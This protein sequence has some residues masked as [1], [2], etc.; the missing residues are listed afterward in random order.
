MEGA[1]GTGRPARARRRRLLTLAACSLPVVLICALVASSPALVG[2]AKAE[3]ASTRLP[4][5]PRNGEMGFVIRKFVPAVIQEPGA[6]PE[7]LALNTREAYLQS[8]PPAERTRLQDQANQAEFDQ[9]WKASVFGP[10]GANVCSQPDAFDRPLLRTVQSRQAVG[11]DLDHDASGAPSADTCQHENFVSPGGEAGIDN[12]AY[13]ALGCTV[14]WRGVDGKAGDMVRGFAQ[15]LASGEWTQ[16]ILLKGV[17]SL[18]QDDD[19][20]VIYGN[21]PDRP[22][23]D[24]KGDFLRDTSFSISDKPPRHRNVLHGHIRDGVLTTDPADIVLTQTWGQGGARDIRGNRTA[25][26]LKRARLRL[27]IAADGTLRGVLGGYEPLFELMSAAALGGAGSALDAGID[28]AAQLRTLQA[29]ADGIK[30]PKTGRC[31]GISTALDV[32]AAPAFVTDAPDG[33]KTA[34]R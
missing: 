34:A 6:C 30:D 13:R 28:C 33:A 4:E 3:D 15:F 20:E 5:I 25:W 2:G 16:V 23:L 1:T 29:M 17:K 10:G 11:L 21:T 12:Q 8:L 24:S 7:G 18:V 19:V 22:L 32:E 27:K 31:T 14:Q 26:T 9:R